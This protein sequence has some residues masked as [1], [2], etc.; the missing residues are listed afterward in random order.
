MAVAQ[1]PSSR[2]PMN[3]QGYYPNEEK[4]RSDPNALKKQANK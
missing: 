3:K 2:Y 1:V 4:N